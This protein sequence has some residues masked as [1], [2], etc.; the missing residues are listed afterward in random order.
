MDQAQQLDETLRKVE[1]VLFLARVPLSNRRVAQLAGLEDGTQARIQ[2]RRLNE[3][4]DAAGRSFHIKQVAGGYQLRT[5]PQFAQ[6][7]RKLEHLPPPSR[8]SGPALETLTVIAYR[9]PIIKADIEAIRGVSCGEMVRQLLEKGLIRISGR[10]ELLGHPFLYS[11]TKL[12]LTTFGLS[13]LESLPRAGKMRG[14]GLPDWADQA[15]ETTPLAAGLKK[16]NTS[17][18][19]PGSELTDSSRLNDPGQAVEWST[20]SMPADP[21][22]ETEFN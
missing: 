5:R 12:F 13:S 8:L 22:A 11:T 9:Q 3:F 2:L 17:T 4:Y 21:A 20:E 19:E 18:A 10:S 15:P 6:W 14:T 7:L 16:T 1:A